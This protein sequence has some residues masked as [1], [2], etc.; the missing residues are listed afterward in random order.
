MASSPFCW[1]PSWNTSATKALATR[2]PTGSTS[3]A[4]QA[5]AK[6]P[7]VTRSLSRP[8][9]SGF[10]RFAKTSP[11]HFASRH[12]G[13]T[14]YLPRA[15]HQMTQVVDLYRASFKLATTTGTFGVE[16]GCTLSKVN[17]RE[18]ALNNCKLRNHSDAS[19]SPYR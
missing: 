12:Y 7:P 4:L 3:G 10:T 15:R 16:L 6:N 2:R 13:F 8:K 14:E 9:T 17:A 19:N 18:N 11:T 1:R 5:G